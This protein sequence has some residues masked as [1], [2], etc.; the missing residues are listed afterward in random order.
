MNAIED[1]GLCTPPYATRAI[2]G[3]SSFTSS[4]TFHVAI[5]LV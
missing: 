2:A 5:S 1:E 4:R 3:L